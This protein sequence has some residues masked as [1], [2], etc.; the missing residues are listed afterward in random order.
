MKGLLIS[1]LFFQILIPN[2]VLANDKHCGLIS[3]NEGNEDIEMHFEIPKKNQQIKVL[4]KVMDKNITEIQ[5]LF[6]C[7]LKEKHIHCS[8]DDDGGDF[9][10]YL[11]E[12]LLS[13]SRIGSGNPDLKRIELKP[14]KKKP[15]KYIDCS[16]LRKAAEK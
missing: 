1:Y 15:F 6:Y 14:I 5:D 8:G 3:L 9:N 7:V 10:L 12:K 2:Y 4:F 13:I 16:V 11:E